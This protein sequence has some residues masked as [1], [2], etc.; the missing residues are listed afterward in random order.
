MDRGVRSAD[1]DVDGPVSGEFVE[2]LHGEFVLLDGAVDET[3]GVVV[4]LGLLC[5]LPHLLLRLFE[6]PNPMLTSW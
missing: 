1:G 4:D 3:E 2:L 5:C 6:L